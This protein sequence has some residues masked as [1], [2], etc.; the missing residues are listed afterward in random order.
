MHLLNF[1]I[2]TTFDLGSKFL[3]RSTHNAETREVKAATL[4][5][6][7]PGGQA[8]NCHNISSL[9]EISD[10]ENNPACPAHNCDQAKSAPRYLVFH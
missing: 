3:L 4:L 9:R 2:L 7:N 10:L 1:L 8:A 5:T 6:S